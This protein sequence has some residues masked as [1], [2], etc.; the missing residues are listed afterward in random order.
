[1]V[2]KSTSNAHFCWIRS[3]VVQRQQQRGEKGPG[4]GSDGVGRRGRVR[5]AQWRG[6]A[7]PGQQR[8]REEE[9][10]RGGAV[11]QQRRGEAGVAPWP[12]GVE[13]AASR[14][15]PGTAGGN[16]PRDFSGWM[17]NVAGTKVFCRYSPISLLSGNG[18]LQIGLQ[19]V[20][21]RRS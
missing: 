13:G 14:E 4:R 11:G 12:R 16:C 21:W 2:T 8:P 7:C 17:R 15:P 6:G 19:I 18:M 3:R 1:V 5:A 10:G 20:C 9:K